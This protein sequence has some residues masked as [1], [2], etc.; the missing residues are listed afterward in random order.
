[1]NSSLISGTQFREMFATA[2]AWLDNAHEDINSLNVFPVPDGDTGTNMLMTMKTAMEEISSMEEPTI[3][4]LTKQIAH[5]TLMGARGNSGVILSQFWAGIN[6]ALKDKEK[7][8]GKDFAVALTEAY[9]KAYAGVANPVEGTILTVIRESAEA[10]NGIAATK[11]DMVSV[12]ETVVNQAAKSVANTPNLLA[13]LREA[14]VVDSGGQGIYIILDGMLRYLKGEADAMQYRKGLIITPN[15]EKPLANPA[16]PE[17]FAKLTHED[18]EK[19]GYCTNVMVRG[20]GLDPDKLR[21]QLAKKG[22]SIVLVGD[23]NIIRLHIHTQNPGE[24]I[25]MMT[26]LGIISDVSICNMDDQHSEFIKNKKEQ[27]PV[28]ATT[29][30]VAVSVGEGLSQLF[31][32]LGVSTVVEGGQTMNP[33]TKDLLNATEALLADNVIILPNNKNI[34]LTA[35]KVPEVSNKKVYVIPTKSIPQGIAALLSYDYSVDVESNVETMKE[36][37]NN[38]KTIEVTRAVRSTTVDGIDIQKKQA[39]GILDGKIVTAQEDLDDA[40]IAAIEKADVKDA[41]IITVYYGQEID[42]EH[43][44]QLNDRLERQYP[45]IGIEVVGGNQPNYHYIASIE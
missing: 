7:I 24:I 4:Q 17:V 23:E 15:T 37:M 43:A 3:G 26:E 25:S 27:D 32:S 20:E 36:A 41:E 19:F 21:K 10:A 40:L 44:Q 29:S 35:E 33:S 14:G 11:E 45:M 8:N 34:I 22:K 6:I 38:V 42:A 18:G 1:M 5:G 30:I 12:L 31:Q 39:I 9:K 2:T 13:T 16:D 28:A